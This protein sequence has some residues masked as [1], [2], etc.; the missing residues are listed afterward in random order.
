MNSSLSSASSRAKPAPALS[1][2]DLRFLQHSWICIPLESLVPISTSSSMPFH[3]LN[4]RFVTFTSATSRSFHPRSLLFRMS[5]CV[6]GCTLYSGY[7]RLQQA[8]LNLPSNRLEACVVLHPDPFRYRPCSN[9]SSLL[10]PS[11]LS[12]DHLFEHLIQTIH[13]LGLPYVSISSSVD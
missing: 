6:C 2:S 9:A 10:L 13:P 4:T 5:V 7:Q 11:T 3:S 12:H 8:V 1:W